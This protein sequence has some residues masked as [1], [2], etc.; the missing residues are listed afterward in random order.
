MGGQVHTIK[1]YGGTGTA[2][3]TLNLSTFEKKLSSNLLLPVK[4]IPK[5]L[6]QELYIIYIYIYRAF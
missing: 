1:V 2:V 3:L 6:S 4:N 5:Q